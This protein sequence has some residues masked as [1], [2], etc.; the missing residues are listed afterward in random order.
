[1]G[2]DSISKTIRL[3]EAG[4]D[5]DGPRSV[6]NGFVNIWQPIIRC[7]GSQSRYE[8]PAFDRSMALCP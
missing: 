1:M 6:I 3:E 2:S 7:A 4:G 5:D 8:V